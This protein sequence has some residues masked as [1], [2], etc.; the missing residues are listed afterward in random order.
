[1]GKGIWRSPGRRV[2]Q[3]LVF[4][5]AGPVAEASDDDD[6]DELPAAGP[7]EGPAE[8][9]AKQGGSAMELDDTSDRVPAESSDVAEHAATKLLG[10]AFPGSSPEPEPEP[11]LAKKPGDSAA[12]SDGGGGVRVVPLDGAA[13][14]LHCG[15]A[16]PPRPHAV[17][18][19]FRRCDHP[20]HRRRRGSNAGAARGDGR[21][22]RRGGC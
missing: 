7:A 1:M 17:G 6:D 20:L 16:N 2:Q 9:P 5:R 10:Q 11:E 3:K 22:G 8:E 4:Q 13:Q 14:P 18:S 21:G 15:P 12:A 19:R